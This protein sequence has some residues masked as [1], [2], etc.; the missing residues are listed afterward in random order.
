MKIIIFIFYLTLLQLHWTHFNTCYK[1][2]FQRDIEGYAMV[3]FRQTK[4][5]LKR[6]QIFSL[7]RKLEHTLSV[8]SWVCTLRQ[9]TVFLNFTIS[10]SVFIK[11]SEISELHN[12]W[13]GLGIVWILSIPILILLIDFNSYRFPV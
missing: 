12:M 8:W 5:T 3:H 6:K 7:F 4:Q 13:L 1:V 2:I 9:R 10:W 11:C